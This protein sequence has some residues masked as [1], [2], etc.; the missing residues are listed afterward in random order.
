MLLL[1]DNHISHITLASFE[2]CRVNGVII[3]SFPPHTS[4]KLQPLNLTVYGPLKK[5][6]AHQCDVF[7]RSNNHE[8]I[9]TYNVAEIFKDAYVRNS[10]MEK[11]QKGFCVSGVVPCNLIQ[12]CLPKKTFYQPH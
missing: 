2:Y 7:L 12:M 9:T 1:L 6:Y 8:K 4:H 10:T 3:L 11:A 5:A